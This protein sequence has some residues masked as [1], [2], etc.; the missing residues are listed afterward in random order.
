[1]PGPAPPMSLQ[2]HPSPYLM[3]IQPRRTVAL[4]IEAPL[5]RGDLAGLIERTCALLA[6]GDVE[7]IVCEAAG[8]R[9]DAVALEALARLTLAARRHRCELRLTL[10]SEQ[11]IELLT[12][13]GLGEVLGLSTTPRAAQAARTAERSSLWPGRR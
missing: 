10:A 1:M 8:V 6:D 13:V 12:L 4:K 3:A 2:A 5:E 11:L 7:V 9:A